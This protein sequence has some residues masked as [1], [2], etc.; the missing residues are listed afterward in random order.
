M[1]FRSCFKSSFVAFRSAVAQKKLKMSQPIRVKDGH[2]WS[3]IGPKNT[4]VVEN[5]EILLSVKFREHSVQ[6]FERRSWKCISQSE[7]VRPSWIS[8]RPDKYKLDRKRWGFASCQ[9]WLK[10]SV[11][12]EKT[13]KMPQTIR[14]QD[15]HLVFSYRPENHK[16]DRGRW[17]LLPVKCRW[18]SFGDNREGVENP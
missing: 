18:I 5:V 9:V 6:H 4:N 13:S 1:T 12:A 11:V 17:N 2:I 14:S 8:D 10:Y 7:A 16:L 15:D 3:S